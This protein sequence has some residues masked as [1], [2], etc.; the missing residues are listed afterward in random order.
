MQ[1]HSF[2]VRVFMPN[3]AKQMEEANK[4]LEEDCI[5]R[6]E[7]EKNMKEHQ[8]IMDETAKKKELHAKYILE[9]EDHTRELNELHKMYLEEQF[10]QKNREI[11]REVLQKEIRQAELEK[12][13][14]ELDIQLAK[15]R[16]A[17]YR[18]HL[19]KAWAEFDKQLL[20]QQQKQECSKFDK[21]LLEQQKQGWTEF[22]ILDQQYQQKQ[23]K[24]QELEQ[25]WT[26]FKTY[27]KPETP[28]WQEE[29]QKQLELQQYL[30]MF[31][32][33]QQIQL[34]FASRLQMIL[35]I[36]TEINICIKQTRD[37]HRGIGDLRRLCSESIQN[38]QNAT[39]Y[40]DYKKYNAQ[41]IEIRNTAQNLAVAP[42]NKQQLL[43]RELFSSEEKV[44]VNDKLGELRWLNSK[45]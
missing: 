14:L 31:N 24:K 13:W 34:P 39:S 8:R 16:E 3:T 25:E 43:M 12:A 22:Q 33:A 2:F 37:F 40:E 20:E 1:H 5:K 17:Q 35:D 42:R 10:D 27:Q 7:Y 15:Q 44:I 11:L 36:E 19:E 41:T 28:W 38:A 29:L 4:R 26:E 6:E 30:Y 32:K 21:Q 45:K 23:K 18:E 9:Q